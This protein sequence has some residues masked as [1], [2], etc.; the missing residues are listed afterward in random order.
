[1]FNLD[2][3][4]FLL[5]Q[6]ARRIRAARDQGFGCRQGT[7]DLRDGT[8]GRIG[9]ARD[10]FH[11]IGG[12]DEG[13]LRTLIDDFDLIVRA[14]AAGHRFAR[15]GPPERLPLQHDRLDRLG[16][17]AA[18]TPPN[19]A[20]HDR[21]G[22]VNRALSAMRLQIDGPRRLQNFAS[23]RGRL[24]GVDVIFDGLGNVHPA[25]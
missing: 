19:G 11:A 7:G 1:M 12:Y 4:N 2:A 8:P 6:D 18:T 25:A 20:D 10:A 14:E 22:E 15:L 23:Y 9:I 24:N 17:T 3:D 13:L 5:P 16:Q 21:I